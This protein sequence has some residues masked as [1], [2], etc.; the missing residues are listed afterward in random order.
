MQLRGVPHYSTINGRR[1]HTV[2]VARRIPVAQVR[3]WC[4]Y[5]TLQRM[6]QK[7]ELAELWFAAAHKLQGSDMICAVC[8][9]GAFFSHGWSWPPFPCRAW[10]HRRCCSARWRVTLRMKRR[11]CWS[12]GRRTWPQP[13]TTIPSRVTRKRRPDLHRA[14]RC[15]MRAMRAAYAAPAATAPQ[16][17]KCPA[18]RRPSRRSKPGRPRLS[19]SFVRLLSGSRTSHLAPERARRRLF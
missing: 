19:C 18:G 14:A 13:G 16:L 1:H 4:P 6:R 11:P 12:T 15:Q 9:S 17:R 10:R 5:L 8:L 3:L 7:Q 2:D